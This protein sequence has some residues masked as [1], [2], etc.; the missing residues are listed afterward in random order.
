MKFGIGCVLTSDRISSVTHTQFCN[1]DQLT[2][3]LA[4]HSSLNQIL[5]QR[6][7]HLL[8]LF[9][10][11]TASLYASRLSMVNFWCQRLEMLLLKMAEE[12]TIEQR[13]CRTFFQTRIPSLCYLR[14][15]VYIL[16]GRDSGAFSIEPTPISIIHITY[17]YLQSCKKQSPGSTNEQ[18]ASQLCTTTNIVYIHDVFLLHLAVR[19]PEHNIRC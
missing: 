7:N 6:L 3:R 4:F 8:L 17:V 12:S 14:C 11:R 10:G 19:R 5:R 9:D 13:Q 15:D 2:I 1:S 16:F 18:L